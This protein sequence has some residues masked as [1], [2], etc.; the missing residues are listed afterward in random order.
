MIDNSLQI[1]RKF[2][3]VKNLWYFIEMFRSQHI[4][5]AWHGSYCTSVYIYIYMYVCIYKDIYV[6]FLG[7]R[8][9]WNG[10]YDPLPRPQ[11]VFRGF[12]FFSISILREKIPSRKI[13]NGA[14]PTWIHAQVKIFISKYSD[15]D[16]LK[17][18]IL[19]LYFFKSTAFVKGRIY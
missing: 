17:I 8:I 16:I 15:I 19:I 11:I 4:P 14:D 5:H 6:M 10:E 12:F 9:L 7:M 18:A 13:L 3:C 1:F 2:L